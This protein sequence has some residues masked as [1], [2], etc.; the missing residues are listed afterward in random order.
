MHPARPGLL[1]TSSSDPS[2]ARSALVRLAPPGAPRWQERPSWTRP[3]LR[4]GGVEEGVALRLAPGRVGSSGCNAGS[5]ARAQGRAQQRH[6]PETN[7]PGSLLLPDRALARSPRPLLNLGRSERVRRAC[8]PGS[9]GGRS[10]GMGPGG[11]ARWDLES[12][13][14]GSAC[15]QQQAS[16]PVGPTGRLGIRALEPRPGGPGFALVLGLEPS[17]RHQYLPGPPARERVELGVQPT[18]VRPLQ[19]EPRSRRAGPGGSDPE[20][21]CSG[22]GSTAV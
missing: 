18:Q 8:A 10:A 4:W 20:D 19:L 22:G 12:R 14:R 7:W 2:L 21:R 1:A 16:W 3:A 13:A 11:L 17:T 5:A 9:R 6:S 15:S